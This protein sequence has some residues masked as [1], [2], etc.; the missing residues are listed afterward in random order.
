MIKL[1]ESFGN[2]QLNFYLKKQNANETELALRDLVT[3]SVFKESILS[4]QISDGSDVQ[5]ELAGDKDILKKQNIGKI[6]SDYSCVISGLKC[7]LE[8][9]A[10][11]LVTNLSEDFFNIDAK[12]FKP[13]ANKGESDPLD[14]GSL[15]L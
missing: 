3:H 11:D 13:K 2:P 5:Q 6:S 1:N 4:F 10:S 9:F 12:P 14:L 8:E 7:F 15:S